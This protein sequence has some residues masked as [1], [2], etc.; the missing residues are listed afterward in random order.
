MMGK[1]ITEIFEQVN[2]RNYPDSK[3]L[4]NFWTATSYR[5]ALPNQRC[6]LP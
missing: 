2:R 1:N 4:S 3:A 5:I 6:A